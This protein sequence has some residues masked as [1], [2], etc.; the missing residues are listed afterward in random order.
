VVFFINAVFTVQGPLAVIVIFG[1][2]LK[3]L[4]SSFSYYTTHVLHFFSATMVDWIS[5]LGNVLLFFLVF[6]MSATVDVACLKTQIRNR[7]AILTGM[8]LQF[9][10]LPFLGFITVKIIPMSQP[11][12]LTLLVVTSSPGGSYSNWYV[13]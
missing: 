6:G 13:D 10:L 12:G 4:Q 7:K 2:F 9:V 1:H 8:A 3:L 11:M 5:V